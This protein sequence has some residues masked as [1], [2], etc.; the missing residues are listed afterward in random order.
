MTATLALNGI[1]NNKTI[2]MSSLKSFEKYIKTRYE[3]I[4]PGTINDAIGELY[5]LINIWV[6][7]GIGEIH[8]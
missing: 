2:L 7:H 6:D 4:T 5:H 1:N 3:E 8:P